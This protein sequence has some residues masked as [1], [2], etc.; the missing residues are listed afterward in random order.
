MSEETEPTA[1]TELRHW[2]DEL[3]RVLK[4]N[5][6]LPWPNLIE[7]AEEAEEWAI[8]AATR[9][10][11]KR[12]SDLEQRAKTAEADVARLTA[13]LNQA[14]KARLT[15]AEPKLAAME[16]LAAAWQREA[17]RARADTAKAA[18]LSDVAEMRLWDAL[19]RLL[20]AD[21]VNEH[22][23]IL[24]SLRY[25]AGQWIHVAAGLSEDVT[26]RIRA[27]HTPVQHMGQT[28]CGE[29][30]VRRSTG[31]REAE[32]VALIPHPCNTLD[33]LEGSVS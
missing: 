15:E 17:E 29:C 33:A 13:E 16:K 32:W 6:A 22:L 1:K 28:W 10:G 19:E 2:H 30:S 5:P 18:D 31:P 24:R 8:K 12:L 3:A 4:A 25:F 23:R 9:S 26:A 21:E 27:L 11:R 7:W 20:T 14:R